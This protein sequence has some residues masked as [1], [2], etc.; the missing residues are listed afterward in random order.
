MTFD[1]FKKRTVRVN[2]K[3]VPFIPLGI[4]DKKVQGRT[5][6]ILHRSTILSRGILTKFSREDEVRYQTLLNDIK[7]GTRVIENGRIVRKEVAK[8]KY[9]KELQKL[10]EKR[11]QLY[12]K[13]P[14]FKQELLDKIDVSINAVQV[15]S[16]QVAKAK[17]IL[18]L[19]ES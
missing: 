5:V 3:D 14:K 6:P 17:E 19:D 4:V 9:P 7:E 2:E 8:N 16:P 13:P 18:K 10:I 11:K 1:F 15:D 12:V